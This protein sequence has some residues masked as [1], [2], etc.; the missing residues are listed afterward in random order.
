MY[1]GFLSF[2]VYRTLEALRLSLEDRLGPYVTHLE[3]SSKISKRS[4]KSGR[5]LDMK[6]VETDL[7]IAILGPH[8]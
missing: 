3:S 8:T 4:V 6:F 5:T 1:K 2:E 7:T